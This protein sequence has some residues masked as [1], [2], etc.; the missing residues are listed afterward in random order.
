MAR[1]KKKDGGGGG[2]AWLVTFS[3]LMTL[4]LTFFV[5]LLSMASMDT[6]VISRISAKD[7]SLSPINLSGPGQMPT[8]I[9]DIALLLLK[10]P[11][12]VLLKQKRLKDLLFPHEILPPDI[13]ASELDQNLEI[14][15]H[16]EGVV[17]VLTDALLFIKDSSTLRPGAGKLLDEL[18]PVMWR[19]NVDVNI[20]GHTSFDEL[21]GPAYELSF[22]RAAMALERFLQSK[23]PPDRFSI[24]GYATDKPLY[25]KDSPQDAKNRRV[26][27]LL[28]TTPRM[29]GYV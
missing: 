8:R 10:D 7:R 23:L 15:A 9:E 25:P 20:S 17:I 12:N 26:E 16:P 3:D 24:S 18:T 29:A 6:T 4:L 22:S 14:L 28:K 1:R 11:E 19:L 21:S 2:A 13:S 5:L 27:I